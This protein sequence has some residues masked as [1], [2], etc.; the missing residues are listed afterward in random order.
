MLEDRDYMRQPEY[1]DPLFRAPGWSWTMVLLIAYTV[2]FV[3]EILVSPAPQRLVPNNAFCNEYLALSKEGMASLAQSI[4]ERWFTPE[5]RA[6]NP[7]AVAKVRAMILSTP[8]QGYAGCCGAI[9]ASNQA[10]SASR[11]AIT[12]GSSTSGYPGSRSQ[13]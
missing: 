7:D 2:V 8:G 4:V 10:F 12:A 1:R 3:A 11:C 9:R 5:F 13:A 6:K